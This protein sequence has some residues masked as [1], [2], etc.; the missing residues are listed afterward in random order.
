[1]NLK[2]LN[3]IVLMVAPLF[4]PLTAGHAQNIAHQIA[5]PAGVTWCD[6]SMIRGLFDEINA[7]RGSK[8]LATLKMD[9]VGMKVAELRAIQFSAYMAANIPGTPGFNPHEGYET[10]A[11]S[12]GYDIVSENLAFSSSSPAYV[13]NVIWQGPLHLAAMLSNYANIA[14]VS[15]VYANGGAPYWTYA[16]GVAGT[17]TTPAPPPSGAASLSSE[18]W[19]FL[20]LI[21]NF[22]AQHGAG[23]LEVSVSLQNASQWMSG[24]MAAKS[25]ASHTDSLGRTPGVRLAAFGY[26]YAPWGENIAG[27]YADAQNT[28]NQWATACDPDATGNCTYA[29]RK[30]M[31]NASF[32]AIGI[33]R[34]YGANSAYGWYWTTDFGGY[35]EQ[36]IP[37]PSPSPNPAPTPITPPV[38]NSFAASPSITT[39]GQPVAL[40]WSVS[41]AAAVAIDQGIGSVSGSGSRTVS[42][43]QTTAYKLTATN[44]GG[45]STAVV[46]VTVNAIDAQPPSVP[47][48]SS[49]VAKSSTVVDLAWSASIDNMGVAAYQI[50]RNGAVLASV[51]G[52]VLSYSDTTASP[53]TTYTYQ[54]RARD[55]AGNYS[56]L[57]SAVFVTTPLALAPL[58]C[59]PPETGAFTGCY[60]NN[61]TLAGSPALTRRDGQ[62]NFDWRGSPGPSVST[63]SFSVRWQGRFS[64]EQGP[65]TFTAITSDGMRL[66]IDG[67]AVL[68]RWRDQP[69][70]IY[71]V[72]QALSEGDHLVVVEYY[73][74]TPAVVSSGQAATLSWSVSGVSTVTI[75]NGVGDVTG[76]VSKPVSPVQ[77]TTYR[78]T[79]ANSNGAVTATATVTVSG[80]TGTQ[81]PS[82]P[83]IVA[84]IARSA[85]RIDLSW[86]VS[87]G[88]TAIAGY[89]ITR[90]GSA[91]AFVPGGT[92]LYSDTTVSPGTE[93]TYHIKARDA[94]GNYSSPSSGA[95]VATPA[96]PALID[97]PSP[98]TEAFTG[99][100]YNNLTLT[101]S[102]ALTRTDSQI[103]FDW[104][105]SPGPS[106]SAGDFSVRW[107]GYFN[108][109]Q[110]TYTFTALTS[111]GMRLY[112]DG[113]LVLDRW[114]DQSPYIYK[115]QRPLSA[116]KHLVMVEYYQRTGWRAA[117]VSWEKTAP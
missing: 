4:V 53:G 28:F 25:Y 47:G 13:V 20:A 1:M 17:S 87:S 46:T 117:H 6:D 32:H 56:G 104:Q 116:G 67:V 30:N 10:T 11:A 78:L 103:N 49:A 73:R 79:A 48:I 81:P 113:V 54:V 44:A 60:Y 110:G 102:P 15:C 58:S 100:Y 71:R 74:D 94:A 70:Y 3:S 105:T 41:G 114:R 108:F 97:C 7:L 22:R 40:S 26:T 38:T 106:V 96:A 55:V 77:T 86:T 12:L 33:G 64:F 9:S 68:D 111:D 18:Q 2:A 16:P 93:Y 39:A 90:N 99:C 34:A 52:T 45:A 107:Q 35:V 85:T 37:N 109:D 76:S 95:T 69:P 59:P 31:L 51:T 80:A 101:G 91:L 75:D 72:P 57:S 19:A 83:T 62:I 98:A 23:P 66:F 36:A 63:D 27:G 82:P 88:S 115:V 84:A 43:P 42:P 14:G 8:G 50:S 5:L 61:I 92:L 65:Y 112:I 24:D 29:H 21:N 89:Q